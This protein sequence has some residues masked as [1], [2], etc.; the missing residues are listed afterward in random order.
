[1]GMIQEF[2]DFINKG[3]VLDLAVGVVMGGAFGK[4]V[5]SIVEDLINPLIGKVMGGVDLASNYV[6]LTDKTF[7]S[8]D[9]AKKA[10]A[11]VLGYGSFLNQVLNFIIV[12]FCIFMIVKAYNKMKKPVEEAPAAPAGPTDVELL[13]EIRDLLAKK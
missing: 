9:E 8:Y 5:T 13:A 10:G 11:A 3:N 1:M 6:N 12:A 7:G 2:K 4:I